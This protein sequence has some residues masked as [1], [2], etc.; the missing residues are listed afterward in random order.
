MCHGTHFVE[1]VL[2]SSVDKQNGRNGHDAFV[3]VEV[4]RA[5]LDSPRF[6]WMLFFFLSLSPFL[7]VYLLEEAT[8]VVEAYNKFGERCGL[9]SQAHL[10]QVRGLTMYVT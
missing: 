2:D 5:Y 1:A 10:L 9:T 3:A 4:L 6:R 8:Y 7:S